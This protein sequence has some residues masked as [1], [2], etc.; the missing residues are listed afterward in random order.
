MKRFSVAIVLTV[1]VIIGWWLRVRHLEQLGLVADEGNQVLAVRGILEHGVP[2]VDSGRLYVRGLPFLYAEAAAAKLFGLNEWSLRIPAVLFSVLELLAAYWLGAALFGRRVGLLT[3][4]LMTFSIWEI[5]LARYA[6]FYTAFQLLYTVSLSCFFR[7][8]LLHQRGYKAWF[9]AA[10]LLTFSFHELGVMLA[11]CFLIPL[12]SGSLTERTKWLF[13][14]SMPALVGMWAAYRAILKPLRGIEDAVLLNEAQHPAAGP[15]RQVAAAIAGRLN[16]PD[17]SV[18]RDVAQAHPGWLLGVGLMALAATVYL[19]YHGMRDWRAWRVLFAVAMVWS[20]FLHQFGLVLVL[21]VVYVSLFALT[22]R[23][24]I[25]PPLRVVYGVSGVCLFFW[26]AVLGRQGPVT[27]SRIVDV[28]FGYPNVYQYFLSWF[29]KGW[30][31]MTGV[32]AVGSFWLAARWNA[33]RA[34]L[35]PLFVLGAFYLPVILTGFLRNDFYE[36]RY[37]FHLYPLMVIIVA[38]TA[39]EAWSRLARAIHLRGRGKRAALASVLGVVALLASQDADPRGALAVSARTYRSAKDP[40][41]G[42]LNWKWYARFHQDYKSPSLYV[43]A[44]LAPGDRVVT[45]GPPHKVA[46]Y[47]YY[48]G[49]VD[50]SVEEQPKAYQFRL[51]NGAL[52]DHVTGSEIIQDQVGLKKVL[53]GE[54]GHGVWLLAD[55]M[56]LVEGNHLFSEPMKAYLRSLAAHPDYVGLDG[57]TF[58]VKVQ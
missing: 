27:P 55:R 45:L 48:V 13:A 23:S 22:A 38:A 32:L 52:M 31:V 12:F 58:A 30:P 9:L 19:V 44:R 53:E 24:L 57:Q 50:Y 49:R 29:V 39:S 42:S 16:V 2:K 41:R 46:I 51:R 25:E 11:A 7:G 33:R 35:A 5:E 56:L 14:L 18:G 17:F 28:L 1:L 36:A 40:I 21:W 8:F 34:A 43:K 20:A 47:Y 6:R 3:A 15:L 54:P 26:L 4:I 10:A 37:T